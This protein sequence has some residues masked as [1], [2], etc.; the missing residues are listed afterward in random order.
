MRVLDIIFPL[1]VM[2]LFYLVPEMLKKRKKQQEYEYP[3]IPEPMAQG[4][5]EPLPPRFPPAET[6]VAAEKVL[7]V[8]PG[9]AVT[10]MMPP[11][12]SVPMA[13]SQQ[14]SGNWQNKLT[15]PL[16]LN[17]IVFSAII[18]PPRCRSQH[19]HR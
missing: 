10:V 17:G 12:V 2:L 19:Y 14:D 13:L 1:L 7:P 11:T 3:E 5:T 9:T 16:V 15:V 18:G 4:R 6:M 8:H